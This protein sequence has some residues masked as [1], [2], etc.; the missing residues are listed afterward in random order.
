[1]LRHAI[2]KLP[3]SD[4]R[5][6]LAGDHGPDQPVGLGHGQVGAGFVPAAPHIEPDAADIV[7]PRGRRFGGG[8]RQSRVFHG[9]MI[10]LANSS[11]LV[12]LPGAGHA[13]AIAQY[14]PDRFARR[15]ILE[16]DE[17]LREPGLLAGQPLIGNRS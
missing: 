6:W 16:L 13:S 5:R 7:D 3:P 9:R 4:R 15:T 2:E 14:G 10:E 11:T 8:L 1:M 17:F 12:V